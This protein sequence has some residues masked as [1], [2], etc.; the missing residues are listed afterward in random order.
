MWPVRLFVGLAKDDEQVALAGI[1]EV[2][3]HVQVGIHARLEYR[4]AIEYFEFRDLGLVVHD[5]LIGRGTTLKADHIFGNFLS[6]AVLG[7]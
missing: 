2:F 5:R 7:I 6:T 4:N 1:L 3:G